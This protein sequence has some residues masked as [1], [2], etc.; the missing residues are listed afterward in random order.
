M[1]KKVFV[2][3][4]IVVVINAN[5]QFTQ[6]INSVIA[7]PYNQPNLMRFGGGGEYNSSYLFKNKFE[8]GVSLS[9]LKF[10]SF[11]KSYN[12]L[13][14]GVN[15]KYYPFNKAQ[16]LKGMYFGVG[17]SYVQHRLRDDFHPYSTPYNNNELYKLYSPVISTSIGYLNKI[18]KVN[19]LY[20]NFEFYL[21]KSLPNYLKNDIYGVKLGLTYRFKVK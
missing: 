6:N 5:A 13:S 7:L 20:T 15:F 12:T 21:M 11:V 19:G 8:L 16:V 4:F 14:F 17:M 3:S 18:E 2:F 1:I 9:A 10:L